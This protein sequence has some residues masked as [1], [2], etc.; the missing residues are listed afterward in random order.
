MAWESELDRLILRQVHAAESGDARK[1]AVRQQVLDLWT[2]NGNRPESAFHL[3]YAKTLLGIDLPEPPPEQTRNRRWHLWGRLRAHDRRGER[4][5]VA[6]LLADPG[7]VSDLLGEPSIAAQCLPI[8]MRSLFWVGDLALAVRAI[9][10]LSAAHAGNDTDMIVDAAL[11]DL[12]SRLE[13]RPEREDAEQTLKVLDQCIALPAFGRL[14]GDVRARYWRTK[15]QRLLRVSEF[16]DAEQ[17]LQ[18]AR[19]LAQ[20]NDRLRSHVAA[21]GALSALHVQTLDQLEP[22]AER[23]EREAALAWLDA[24]ATDPQRGTPEALYVRGV[25]AYE[26]S[27]FAD[28]QRFC[29]AAVEASRRS[30]G[31]DEALLHRA[32][33]FLAA[34][35]LAG[36]DQNEAARALH[37]ME[38]ALDH[39][40]PDLE[41]FFPVHEALK[42]LSRKVALSFLDAVDIGRGT[43]PDQLLFVALEYQSLGEAEPAARAAERVLQ[44]AVNLD[45]RLEAM[46]VLLTCQNMAGR[47]DQAR[48][49]FFAIRDL[50]MQRGAFTELETLLKNEAFVGQALDHHEIKCELVALY[51]ELDGHDAE[52]ATLQLGI[53]RS[54]RARKDEG[55]LREAWG[56]LKEVEIAFPELAADELSAIGKLLELSEAKPVDADEGQRRAAAATQALGHPAR[57]LVVGGN[58]RQR[59]HHP[60]LTDLAKS[61]EFEAEWL[62]TNYSSPQKIVNAIADRMRGGRV[63]VLV[64]LH[65][66]RHE[67]TE[68]ALELARKNNVV[69]RTVHYAGFTSLQ[70]GLS[71]LLQTLAPAATVAAEAKSGK[72]AGKRAAAR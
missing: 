8:V 42:R 71:D 1:T 20:G 22:R 55:A 63:D 59:R 51:E 29:D 7:T 25:L 45:Q 41:S 70:V 2:L 32:R 34:A 66:N 69:A 54:L 3:G 19:T 43:A 39:V 26:T 11:N 30:D 17:A 33:F 67:T 9:E 49:T 18:Q 24:A 60:R 15:A 14:P 10:L 64:L 13:N 44:V 53:A 61:W 48:E 36:G 46:R 47:R 52:K 27:S 56:I 37:L 62:E 28:A 16:R 21:L 58:E 38:Q 35:I 6:D 65:W 50:L 68:P 12:L 57:V 40:R 23:P 31:R 4:N 72:A 5:W